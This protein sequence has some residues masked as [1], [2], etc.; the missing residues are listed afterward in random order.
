M[1]THLLISVAPLATAEMKVDQK[2]STHGVRPASETVHAAVRLLEMFLKTDNVWEQI[3]VETI[4]F[5]KE[6]DLVWPNKMTP[7][8]AWK[9]FCGFA[10]TTSRACTVEV[11]TSA[12]RG[13]CQPF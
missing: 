13:S 7:I 12:T 5:G 1:T 6:L 11:Y 10:T 4:N 2:M 3:K 9:H 8:T